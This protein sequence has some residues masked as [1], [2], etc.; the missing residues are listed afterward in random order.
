[1]M[2]GNEAYGGARE[3]CDQSGDS[4]N[5]SRK[6]MAE[7]GYYGDMDPAPSRCCRRNDH[8]HFSVPVHCLSRASSEEVI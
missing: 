1:M 3:G 7:Y 4:G 8:E 5:M 2:I 6:T